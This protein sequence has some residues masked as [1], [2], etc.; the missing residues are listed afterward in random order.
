[1]EIKKVLNLT[2]LSREAVRYYEDEKLLFVARKSNGYR[3]FSPENVLRLIYIKK[4]REA[5]MSMS[6]IREYA[7]MLDENVQPDREQLHEFLKKE[8]ENAHKRLSKMAEAVVKF[9]EI[10]NDYDE[11]LRTQEKW[12]ADFQKEEKEDLEK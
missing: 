7:E 11:N 5:G 8:A 2:G 12:L 6:T 10:V 9:D 4:F 3:D 1:M